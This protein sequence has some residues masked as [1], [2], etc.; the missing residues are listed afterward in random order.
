M[1]GGIALVGGGVAMIVL[2]RGDFDVDVPKD[3]GLRLRGF[4]FTPPVRI[5]GETLP[6]SGSLSFQF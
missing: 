3:A 1:A 6:A 4:A 5:G 2:S